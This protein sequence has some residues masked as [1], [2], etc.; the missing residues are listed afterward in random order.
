MFIAYFVQA[1][2]GVGEIATSAKSRPVRGLQSLLLCEAGG[3]KMRR[4]ASR[5][6]S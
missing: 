2:F 3:E 6:L 5:L 1:N 4:G